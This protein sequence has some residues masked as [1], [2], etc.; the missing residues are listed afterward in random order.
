M[1]IALSQMNPLLGDFQANLARISCDI[2]AARELGADL[3]AFPELAVTGYPPED[4]LLKPGFLRE[5]L[6]IIKKIAEEARDIIVVAGFVDVDADIYNAAAVMADGMVQ[7]V[8]RKFYLPT[9]GVFDEDRYF[10]R[11]SDLTVFRY[12]GILFGVTVCEDIWYAG[13][14]A[15]HLALVGNAEMI[16]NIN[17]SPYH[18]SKW[19]FREKMLAT[20]ASDSSAILAWVNQVGGQD[21]LVFDGHSLVFDPRGELLA[22]AAMFTEELLVA[23][24]DLGAVL[25]SRLVDPR[26]RKE[27]LSLERSGV[28]VAETLLPGSNLRSRPPIARRVADP[29]DRCAEVYE[30]LVTGTRDYINKNGFA[31]V[32]IGISGGIDSALVACIAVDALGPERVMLVSMPSQFSSAETQS[33]AALIARNLGVRFHEVPI[34]D[35][36]NSWASALAPLFEGTQ[37]GVA[38]ENLQARSRGNI[39]MAISNKFGNLVLT[40]GNKSEMACGYATLYGDMAGG[41]AVI[42][43]VPKTIVYDLCE[44]R[45]RRS[46]VIPE[47][48]ITRPPSAELRPDQKDTD[49][50]PPYEVLDPIIDAYVEEDHSLDEMVAL[51]LDE[52]LC[53]RVILMVDRNEYKRRQ[54]PPGVKITRKAFGRDRRLPITNRFHD[55]L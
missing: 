50:L 22:R 48:I 31:S 9:Y 45:N 3:V 29:P 2:T 16:I 20:R 33:D 46:P 38:E 43:D 8:H 54:A 42:K 52:A 27:R 25:R 12:G 47:A 44:W 32:V 18:L 35:L 4:L 26:R 37:P 19:R 41:F 30:A 7:G 21:E 1:R 13:G 17:A 23:D 53:R 28:K 51:G 15:H 6:S 34:R 24:L 40:T 10:Q 14:P 5:N 36:Q 39:L 55:L 49:S 11:G